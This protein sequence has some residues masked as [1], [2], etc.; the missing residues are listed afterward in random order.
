VRQRVLV[1]LGRRD[2]LV[3]DGRLDGLVRSLAKFSERLRVVE[4][5]R[6][7]GLRAH[8]AREWGPALIFE[9]LWKEQRL[10]ELLG[11][12]ASERRFEFNIERASFALALQRLCAPGSD[13]QGSA[14]LPTVECAGFD[15]L[16]LQH[17]YRT[18]GFLAG[19]R[20]RLEQA[21][22]LQDRD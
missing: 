7:D 21:L 19:V 6:A 10:P 22:F 5:V 14:W 3:A 9:R 18:V 2:E 20:E 15:Q 17:L 12:L 11:S 16:Q 8:V 4:R 1:T 13:L